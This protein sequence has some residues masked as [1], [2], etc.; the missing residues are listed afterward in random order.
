M[1]SRYNGDRYNGSPA[2][3][4]ERR[5]LVFKF[6]VIGDYGVGKTSIV[7]RYTEGKFSSNYK[8]TVGADFCVRSLMWDAKTRVSLQLWD[9]AGHERFSYMTR[10]YYKYAI[11]C[12]VVFDVTR[13]SSFNSVNRWVTDLNDKVIL[14]DGRPIPTVLFANKSDIG[15]SCVSDEAI[16]KLCKE[17]GILC[18]FKTSAK[19]DTNIEEGLS[20]LVQEAINLTKSDEHSPLEKADSLVLTEQPLE[21]EKCC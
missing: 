5:D 6:L 7:R 14:D 16:N 9:I 3:Q 4:Q 20:R 8:L 18:W 12:A 2:K 11:G 21:K 13:Y 10:V 17:L 1:D 19:S 15:D